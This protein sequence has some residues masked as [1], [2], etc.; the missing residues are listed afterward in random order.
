MDILWGVSAKHAL[1]ICFHIFSTDGALPWPLSTLC[2][3][4]QR[5]EAA[6]HCAGMCKAAGPFMSHADDAQALLVL[7][8]SWLR[9]LLPPLR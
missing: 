1:N 9:R 2:P 7:L 3:Y 5:A 8:P 6:V 4:A